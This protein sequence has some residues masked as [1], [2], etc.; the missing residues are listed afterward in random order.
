MIARGFSPSFL[1]VAIARSQ[2]AGS[3]LNVSGAT[4]AMIGVAP[5]SATISAVA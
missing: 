5:S 1:A 2:L 4:S 3:R